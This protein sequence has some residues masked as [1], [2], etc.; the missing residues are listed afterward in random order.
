MA[1]GDEE[2]DGRGLFHDALQANPGR[3]GEAAEVVAGRVREV[4]KDDLEE[5]GSRERPHR[6]DGGGEGL[7]ARHAAQPEETGEIDAGRGGGGGVE[8]IVGV[9]EGGE[10]PR[11]RRARD[12]GQDEA[13]PPRRGGAVDFGELAAREAAAE[14]RVHRPHSRGERLTSPI[15]SPKGRPVPLQPAG[16]EQVLES[17]LRGGRHFIRFFFAILFSK[18]WVVKPRLFVLNRDTGSEPREGEMH[19]KALLAVFLVVSARAFAQPAA[20]P[21]SLTPLRLSD[22]EQEAFLREAEIVKT[23]GAPGGITGSTRA[24]LRRGDVVHDAHIQGIDEQKAQLALGTGLELD[25]RDSWRNNVAAYRLDRVLGLGMVPVTVTRRW[26]KGEASF[27]WWVDD[28]LMVEQERFKKKLRAPDVDEWN[29]QMFV[30]RAF[31]QLI[32]NF[33]R[34]LG[35]LLID[36]QWNI[37]MIDH[38]RAFKIFDELKSEKNLGDRCA[39]DFLASLK[40]LDKPTLKPLM[41]DLLT[42]GQIDALLARRDRIV[43]TYEAKIGAKG[44]E[45]VLYDL[46]ARIKAAPTSAP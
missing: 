43:R 25:F 30:V 6:G 46:P 13:G 11:S 40:K 1:F 29:R 3:S 19:R 24:T 28:V 5:A 35:N 8:A 39:R 32:Y 27:T 42:E 21:A 41:N 33:D 12:E 37:W 26:T 18:K 45:S 16:P 23:K 14:E 31:D 7:G 20:L 10:R 15:L 9:D 36:K 2:K 22:A 4:E 17:G 38:T 34:N 44:E